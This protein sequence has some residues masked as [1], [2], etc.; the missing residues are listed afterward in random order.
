M[1][2]GIATGICVLSLASTVP[3]AEAN[4]KETIDFFSDGRITSL[5]IAGDDVMQEKKE[6]NG[7]F[8]LYF[9]G[10][11]VKEAPLTRVTPKGDEWILQGE[12][13]FP[14]FTVRIEPDG[15]QIKLSLVRIEGIASGKDSSLML[16][17]GTSKPLAV[18]GDGVEIEEK[19]DSLSLVW[20]FIGAPEALKSYKPV[21]VGVKP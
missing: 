5:R 14:R 17:L 9:N 12:K 6:R 8:I 18:R 2:K 1:R 16:R 21:I 7:F 13:D 11:G 15:R 10:G 19:Q 4:Q 20:K 3:A